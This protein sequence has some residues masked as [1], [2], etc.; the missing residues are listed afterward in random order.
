[1]VL[2][3]QNR[4]GQRFIV[5]TICQKPKQCRVSLVRE[6]NKF[7]IVNLSQQEFYERWNRWIRGEFLQ[8][9]FSYVLNADEREFILSGTTSEEWDKLF[10]PEKV[11]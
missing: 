11:G 2:N 3:L 9:V 6:P 7:M 1:M 8:N 5:S 4:I 10:P